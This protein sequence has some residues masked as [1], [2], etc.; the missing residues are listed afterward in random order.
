MTESGA[1]T[2][3]G[4]ISGSG[5]TLNKQGLGSLTLS[6]ASTYSG[7]TTIN[8]GSTIYAGSDSSDI[9]QSGPFG[10]GSVFV[11]NG[12]TLNLNGHSI[13]NSL[14][15]S[16]WGSNSGI[17]GALTN[18]GSSNSVVSGQVV[19]N[20]D[21]LFSGSNGYQING[22]ISGSYSLSIN[23]LTSIS[24][25]KPN[26][27]TGSTTIYGGKLVLG[28]NNAIPSLGLITI[29]Y[30]VLDINGKNPNITNITTNNL[31]GSGYN[32]SIVDSL[33]SGSITSS[34]ININ[35]NTIISAV[36][37]GNSSVNILSGGVTLTLSNINSYY[38]STNIS[39][40]QKLNITSTGSISQSST[41][42]VNGTLD[43]SNASSNVL[44]KSIS[45]TNS[46]G[47]IILG[48]NSL[49]LTAPNDIFPGVI[50]SNQ[51]ASAGLLVISG[52]ETFTNTNTYY[53]ATTINS[54]AAL[55]FGS[56]G[57]ALNSN[58][59]IVNGQLDITN[60]GGIFVKSLSGAGSIILGNVAITISNG[61]GNIFSGV[62]SGS[63]SGGGVIL[64]SGVITFTN[65]NTYT[66]ITTINSGTL[67]LSNSG[68][69]EQSSAVVLNGLGSISNFDISNSSGI[70]SIKSL[71]GTG[72]LNL[73]AQTI[74]ITAA[75]DNFSGVISGSG[76][77]IIGSL[78][79]N[80]ASSIGFLGSNT[81]TG[82]TTINYGSNLLL[83]SNGNISQSSN[84]IVKGTFDISNSSISINNINNLTDGSVNTGN[85][86]L[87]NN[88][89]N[90]NGSS[91]EYSGSIVGF[92]GL[93]LSSNSIETLSGVNTY[94]GNT[95]IELGSVLKIKNSGT[96]QNSNFV[97]NGT[98]DISNSTYNISI[99]NLSGNGG[100]IL[101]SN[102]LI[103]TNP[104]GLFGGI[105]SGSG[106]LSINV[107]SS[108]SQETLSGSN[109]YSGST[110]VSVN[111]SLYL[112]S[113]GSI[114]LS[115]LKVYGTFDISN[116]TTA[117][118]IKSIS[119]NGNIILS[120][121]SLILT[122]A[123]DIF[124]G[125]ISGAGGSFTLAGG[126]QTLTGINSYT[127]ITTINSG[128]LKL[129]NNSSNAI[130]NSASI[131]IGD[132]GVV[133]L[134]G[135]SLTVTAINSSYTN[136][137]IT[138]SG[139]SA[140]VL[141]IIGS[142]PGIYSGLIEDG[143]NILGLTLN[144]SGNFR[145]NQTPT[146]SG[147]TNISSNNTLSLSGNTNLNNSLLNIIGSFD[148][149][150]VNI[151]SSI[152]SLSGNGNVILGNNNLT[153]SN[154]NDI[155]AGV[156]S[157]Q[158]GIILAAGTL[159][160]TNTNTYSGFTKINAGTLVLANVSGSSLSQ[161]TDIIINNNGTLDLFGNSQT[162]NS[163]NSSSINSNIVNNG[164]TASTLVIS[165][166]GT[167][168][169]AGNIKDGT[170][171]IGLSLSGIG[172]LT[173]SQT[174]T[175]SGITTISSGK[176]LLG[177]NNAI[178]SSSDLIMNGSGILDLSGYS[179]TILSLSSDNL[180]NSIIL[181]SFINSNSII[182]VK[183]TKSTLYT[184]II[185]D[186]S[187]TGGTIS[188]VVAGSS[189]LK[190][191]GINTYTGN[192]NINEF[193]T[194]ILAN[195]NTN[196]IPA[197]S[198][199]YLNGNGT[200]DIF[201]YSQTF[202]SI[203][204]SSALTTITNN[205]I[206]PATLTINGI[207]PGYFNGAIKDGTSLVSFT[208]S[209]TGTYTLSG[210]N[211]FSGITTLNSGTLK[212][213]STNSFSQNSDVVMNSNSALDLASYSTVIGSLSSSS[214]Q[215]RVLNSVSGVSALSVSGTHSTNF[216]GLIIDNSGSGTGIVSLNIA[217]TGSLALTGVNQFSGGLTLSSGTLVVSQDTNL[218][219]VPITLTSGAL[220]F[221]GGT[222]ENIQNLTINSYRGIAFLNNGGNL[223]VDTNTTLIY[224][225]IITGTG[226]FTKSGLGNLLLTGSN[227]SGSGATLTSSY[228]GNVIIASGS[229]IIQNDSPLLSSINFSGNG[230]LIIQP[231]SVSFSSTISTSSINLSSTLNSLIIG[232]LGNLTQLTIDSNISTIGTQTYYGPVNIG[233]TI[234]NTVTLSTVSGNININGTI[235]NDIS[236]LKTLIINSAGT[237]AVNINSSIGSARPLG[238]VI[239]NAVNGVINI[240]GNISTIAA[241]NNGLYGEYYYNKGYF[242]DNL[243]WFNSNQ[244]TSNATYTTINNQSVPELTDYRFTAYFKP[245]V[246]GNYTFYLTSDDSS[247]MYIGTSGQIVSDLQTKLQ[248]GNGSINNFPNYFIINNSGGHGNTLVSGVA[249]SLI[250]GNLYPLVIYYANG[251]GA[252]G[253]LLNYS[254]PST[255]YN[256]T[257]NLSNEFY[258]L[259]SVSGQ[260]VL[261][262]PVVLT[263]NTN[264][265]SA[266]S[267]AAAIVGGPVSANISIDSINGSN[268]NLNIISGSFNALNSIG[269]NQALNNLNI[270]AS[271]INIK[272][273]QLSGLLSVTN[274]GVS[275]ISGA[276][277]G[278][279]L[280]KDGIGNLTLSGTNTYSQATTIN[281]GIFTISSIANLGNTNSIIINNNA[282]I[283]ISGGLS[284]PVSF[285]INGSGYLN[286]GAIYSSAG[287][288]TITSTINTISN[289][290]ISV[291][292]GSILDLSPS[293]T[294]AIIGL[295]TNINFNGSGTS[296]I[297]GYISIGS[298]SLVIQGPGTVKVKA[299][300]NNILNSSASFNITA[301]TFD[302]NSTSQIINSVSISGGSIINGSIVSSNNVVFSNDSNNPINI[303]ASITGS[304]TN[305]G[306]T[307]LGN[308]I[309]TLS[310]NNNFSGLIS[311]SNGTL[312]LNS[313][314]AIGSNVLST[315]SFDG[316]T[317]QYSNNNTTDYSNRFSQ[318]DGQKYIVNLANQ[319]ITWSSSLISNNSLLYINDSI[320]SG[321]LNLQN[322]NSSSFSAGVTLNKG[323]LYLGDN[324]NNSLGTAGQIIFSGGILKYS[325][326]NNFDYSSIFSNSV[327][328]N[329]Q[330]DTNGQVISW[331]SRLAPYSSSSL[332]KYGSGT[333]ILVNSTNSYSG[334]TV[335]NSGTIK[336][337]NNNVIPSTS[338][339]S[340]N[341]S[342][343]L[344]MAGF[345][346]TVAELSSNST[347][348]SITNSIAN[349][350]IFTTSNSNGG[351]TTTY[352]GSINNGASPGMTISL[353]K[354]GAYTLQLLGNSN[355][356]GSTSLQGG[357]INYGS[358]NA[359]G[360]T[361]TIYFYNN[362]LIRYTNSNTNDI[363]SRL[364][365]I[366]GQ[367]YYIDL[368]GYTVNWT[369]NLQPALNKS[370]SLKI[371]DSSSN[372]ILSLS[373]SNS[374]N[375]GIYLNSGTL[376][377]NSPNAIDTSGIV[378][379]NGGNLKFSANNTNDY[380]SVF[381]NSNNQNY[382][383]NLNNQSITFNYALSS[384]GGSLTIFDSS[385]LK[386]GMLLLN[387][388]N[389]Y[390]G[391]TTINSG[392]LKLLANS[393]LPNLKQININSGVLD[394]NGT[395]QSVGNLYL[396]TASIID[397]AITKGTLSA[398]SFTI[399]PY[400]SNASISANLSG[401]NAVLNLNGDHSQLLLS[402]NNSYSGGTT[403]NNWSSLTIANNNSLPLN[404]T[405]NV[406]TGY[407]DING[408]SP[409]LSTL[410]FGV[411]GISNSGNVNA[412]INSSNYIINLRGNN[413]T[414]SANLN[415]GSLALS[416]GGTL[417]L[418]GSNNYSGGTSV[419][420]AT[421]LIS[422]DSNL[423]QVIN[424]NQLIFNEGWLS[425]SANVTINSTRNIVNNGGRTLLNIPN[426]L[427]LTYA[428]IIS[429]NGGLYKEGYG[430]FN[431]SGTASF[432]NTTE[433]NN[434]SIYLSGT[435][436][437]FSSSKLIL[438]NSSVFDISLSN[439]G[440][441][442]NRLY[443]DYNTRIN[444][445]NN[446]FT[447]S[448]AD[449]DAFN[450]IMSSSGINGSF[451]LT[452]GNQIFRGTNNYLGSTTIGSSASLI[453]YSSGSIN[454]GVSGTYSNSIINNG[455]LEYSSSS[456]LILSGLISGSGRLV[457]YGSA[458][459]T[460][461]NNNTF[462]GGI[463]LNSGTLSISSDGNL[464]LQPQA[465]SQSNISIS[466]ATLLITANTDW[467]SNRGLYLSGTDYINVRQ[468]NYLNINSIISGSF[469]TLILNDQG[470][471]RFNGNN[472]YTG[473][474]NVNSG[475]LTINNDNPKL[476]G[477]IFNGNGQLTIQ[478]SSANFS[479]L[480]NFN[481]LKL[482]QTLSSLTIG[483]T[484]NT[485]P[486]NLISDISTTG[487]QYYYGP[488]L[489]SKS[490]SLNSSSGN[491]SFSSTVDS[492]TSTTP[493][494]LTIN[495][496]SSLYKVS[497][498]DVIGGINP[499]GM[500][501]IN[502]SGGIALNSN[503]F[504]TPTNFNN[505][506]KTGLVETLFNSFYFNNNL[507]LFA[508]NYYSSSIF[509][510][511][512][513]NFTINAPNPSGN[514]GITSYTYNNQNFSIIFSGYYIP[515]AS[516]VASF[517][518]TSTDSSYVYLGTSGQ[519]VS[520]LQQNI[521]QS[522]LTNI[523]RIVNNQYPSGTV[524]GNT[525]SLIAGQ[526]Y[527]ILIY[528]GNGSDSGRFS[529][530]NTGTGQYVTTPPVQSGGVVL[531]GPV[532]LTSNSTISTFNGPVSFTNILNGLTSGINLN[533]N[534]G[535]GN[536]N[537]NGSV[538]ALQA[539]GNISLAG[540]SINSSL[541]NLS[542]A[543]VITNS[544]QS[545]IGGSISGTSL[546]KNGIGNLI[547]S[548]TNTYS[549]STNLNAGT[550]TLGSNT[551]FSSGSI[552]NINY[553]VLDMYSYNSTISNL[554]I[555]AG[556]IINSNIT[557]TSTLTATQF[558]FNN[559]VSN[560]VLV[561]VVLAGSNST[562]GTNLSG[563]GN[564]TFTGINTYTG[565]T[566]VSQV[567]TLI[568]SGSGSIAT[569][570][571]LNLNGVF[572]ISNVTST[573]T[574]NGLSGNSY[575]SVLT[576]SKS[577]ILSNPLFVTDV[578]YGVI[579]GSG[580][581]VLNSGVETLSG[582][583]TYSG[584]TTIS[585]GS[586]IIG[587]AGTLGV[588]SNYSGSISISLGAFFNFSSSSNQILSG[589]ISG[590]GGIVK[591][592][593]SNSNLTISNSNT[594]SGST[595]IKFGTIIVSNSNSLGNSSNVTISNNSSL[596]INGNNLTLNQPIYLNG[597]GLNNAGALI[598]NGNN[599]TIAGTIIL[600]S[601]SSV[602]TISGNL[603]LNGLSG[604][605]IS[606]SS[607]N[608]ILNTLSNIYI[609]NSIN[610]GSGSVSIVG[611][612]TV[613]FSGNNSYTGN[614]N[615]SN[616]STLK[617]NLSGSISS[618]STIIDE[619]IF[620]ITNVSSTATIKSLSSVSYTSSVLLGIKSLIISSGND[621]FNGIISGSGD[622]SLTSGRQ[623][624][625][626]ANLY[627]GN[628]FIN[629]GTL[630]ISGSGSLGLS[631]IYSSTIS[632][633]NNSY[634]YYS[635]SANQTISGLI[636]GL[637]N[638]TKD[639]SNSSVLT[640][641]HTNSYSG[642]TTISSG[643]INI[644]NNMSLGSTSLVTVFGGAELDLNGTTLN[645]SQPIKLNGAVGLGA[646]GALVNVTGNN[647]IS[648]IILLGGNGKILSS[649]G[650]ITIVGNG[651]KSI[652]STNNNLILS[653][654]TGN[655]I[656]SNDISIGTGS[657]TIDGS[658]NVTLTYANSFSGQTNINTGSNLSI[659]GNGSISN[660]SNI[661]INGLLDISGSYANA[662][663]S[664]I[665]GTNSN[666]VLS[667]GSK[668]LSITNASNSEFLGVISGFGSVTLGSGHQIL[669][670]N[671]TYSGN[672]IINSGTLT[673]GGSGS[674][675]NGNYSGQIIINQSSL[676]QYSSS[677]NQ[678]LSGIISGS[679]SISKDINNISILTLS[680]S[681]TYSGYSTINNG[682]ILVNNNN[683]LGVS[684][685][686]GTII[687]YNGI[688]ALSGGLTIYQPIT[689]G[690]S[691]IYSAKLINVSGNNN[692][693]KFVS[694]N[695]NATLQSLTG[696]LSIVGSSGISI[697]S[698]S[699]VLTLDANS[700]SIYIN[701]RI[702]IGSGSLNVTGTGLVTLSSLNSYS[703]VTNVYSG[704]SLILN[705]SSASISGS[706]DVI[707]N[708]LLDLVNV[709]NT[710]LQS[711]GGSYSGLIN[712]GSSTLSITAANDNF[713]G[714]ISGSG[715]SVILTG[716]N[717]AFSGNN[718]FTGGMFINGG[719]LELRS[720]GSLGAISNAVT[721]NNATVD[722]QT[723]VTVGSL[724]M[725][726]AAP[727]IINS[728]GASS[729]TVNGASTLANSI[730]TS[731]SQ[732]YSGV[733]TLGANTTLSGASL[734]FGTTL[735]GAR[736]LSTRT[737]GGT[738]FSGA[739]GGNTALSGLTLTTAT[740]SAGAINLSNAAAL[741]V[742]E[743][744]AGTITGVI[745]EIGRA[746]V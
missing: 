17:T 162:I 539:F 655:I 78:V 273:I 57:S 567:S 325:S 499:L 282:T 552:L 507:N 538:G 184:G 276:Y 202:S 201:G 636:S 161:T 362:S 189:T 327:V 649:S 450:G 695:G 412:S 607:S 308:G 83:I 518:T 77:I 255:S 376:L 73:G 82:T 99:T 109:T 473:I 732:T 253:I 700:G 354:S 43:L 491:I 429:G 236:N 620:D 610:I 455:T 291:A 534:S 242:S 502:S 241:L 323:T 86:K 599:N 619:G 395:T 401:N 335:I 149:T 574:I 621:T 694:L 589:N 271:A 592:L 283:S 745:S 292:A 74:S 52:R 279:G 214:L 439:T 349:S 641:S 719:Q 432:T 413:S 318:A 237:G 522:N 97:V 741:S 113:S 523:N 230:N 117:V 378:N 259:S 225:G 674:L 652:S 293:S 704:S 510:S 229:L 247:L 456:N 125:N 606:S 558:N 330:V 93:K 453:F 364:S 415:G 726:G 206:S 18:T 351:I 139:N 106:G 173:L 32:V 711:I 698:S 447:I 65:L 692:I 16:G 737:T 744:G 556:S 496:A 492:S 42:V 512:A 94:L 326:S 70:V 231:N 272:D 465:Y 528:Y 342:S 350:S 532:S 418:S 470:S 339:L 365:N 677:V 130:P 67:L 28:D 369:A 486:I 71:R 427:T 182:T 15:L 310:G 287:S 375:S 597:F 667:L 76:N 59:Y 131:I 12:A 150:N 290:L 193:A 601:D 616:L 474:I 343:T 394:I 490:I 407:L 670:G 112:T 540:S 185:K 313:A 128:T 501:V 683:S 479:N 524:S 157:G 651:L 614:T 314:G 31:Y 341:N 637:G 476:S 123:N 305:F 190:L 216:A 600:Q 464:G 5:V 403:I 482:P 380:S 389:S 381:S 120:S 477:I 547:L 624:L 483:K 660:S 213:G 706:S 722:L 612:G 662:I 35:N 377:L 127:G 134:A 529:F 100:F 573:S 526:V 275:N 191:T 519:S 165:G 374:F 320:G 302:E 727:V 248:S 69:I 346:L 34:S 494:G 1:G 594:Y 615:I 530:S 224:Q 137:K 542:G 244:P 220:S 328:Q 129:A 686:S 554:N 264:I 393:S 605:S 38:G 192:T 701:N 281:N 3:T 133:D 436:S 284:I 148:I 516:G 332:T 315:I 708:G 391:V 699:G 714:V 731:G 493:F 520:L 643:I 51:V 268:N 430:I 435:G 280:F 7:G 37:S 58:N 383:I 270:N 108:S 306:L 707:V 495:L 680:N 645:I 654:N 426:G 438:R 40:G 690:S 169:F 565:I 568:L 14:Y 198:T 480:A 379:F 135:Y 356:S 136:S 79:G 132:G 142:T 301:G 424:T 215:T 111:A 471:V 679:G 665:G 581:L 232:K 181:N 742:T 168:V 92:G 410:Y 434:G 487:S 467:N 194:L 489:L 734:T 196:T 146:Y 266:P 75:S 116:S 678:L 10:T 300:L 263:G 103:L 657:L 587:G 406:Y 640:L 267:I 204:G 274:T 361:G 572:D 160:L 390:S 454:D 175:Y 500:L 595:S 285:A 385:I 372:G 352:Y 689:I 588:S 417:T 319:N 72:N 39:N 425:I 101:G 246:S 289:S 156:I 647:T 511:S 445:G 238:Q 107:L 33:N 443:G 303:T 84:V 696:V 219:T 115:G 566:S 736:T 485:T 738:T 440:A 170:G 262:G 254:G 46:A 402:G 211:T 672:T 635:S 409:T 4:V 459:L 513:T 627:S 234:V 688:L 277:S 207:T 256:T 258:S 317:L 551:V 578:F 251:G 603:S 545:S 602:S 543:L 235:D 29:Y 468:N 559:S 420:G 712:L 650:S 45:G 541:I 295:N 200:L 155:F 147:I 508:T 56:G 484:G 546:T 144:G 681:N 143:S 298:G 449:G 623:G 446:P 178:S 174:N 98:V 709:G 629:G 570:K 408:F 20:A 725:S 691:S 416:N 585:A 723:G 60:S 85:I 309:L 53:G 311:I 239:I 370:I 466:N 371:I 478:P 488:L 222:L 245:T 55:I 9:A 228:S 21:T 118:S 209:S 525:S 613:T 428:G 622:L 618:S 515:D 188:L 122:A 517:S 400:Y 419:S 331:S 63:G 630:S 703:G 506:S 353:V 673:I 217:T 582:A 243:T 312:I 560:P 166:N 26:I 2:I 105:I 593:S 527:P 555:Y 19:L 564:V 433:I 625:S 360:S 176:L 431:Y 628:T 226:G 152:K 64:N 278:V 521:Q 102:N 294:N 617:L 221:K 210:S 11:Q 668:S 598:N 261:N 457:T 13:S 452:A 693:S 183:G 177:V 348:A 514:S 583:N 337:G 286:M 340:I 713:M 451:S 498:A 633:A 591:D 388:T 195:N 571:D 644:T 460:L 531:N 288:N 397:S 746:H 126:I 405:V 179:Q 743:S 659:S 145:L 384:N 733:V 304:G 437:I 575:G 533:I 227:T 218:G 66:G 569:S 338:A 296:N 90:L 720:G 121:K 608:L 363:S 27:Y 557:G 153:I 561:S 87:G 422:S 584:S 548:G 30:G 138:N 730:T 563:A 509:N 164:I 444:F 724:V 472:T 205:G 347:S 697:T 197:I 23:V 396:N 167:S 199:I 240:G 740:L 710:S 265:T 404:S 22:V 367:L 717:Q 718:S 735:D 24:F 299:G 187:G 269:K 322:T 366:D 646:S 36:I 387:S 321:T 648:N 141:T 249:S 671:N 140:V 611:L 223:L 577:L 50:S 441:S 590:A 80:N 41:L 91:G 316:G 297:N 186:N 663:V 604:L 95:N 336:L 586:L 475:S 675:Q 110:T 461:T 653:A 414:I 358:S 549:S 212:L 716:G 661:I 562:V 203:Y 368:N 307:K 728:T 171:T 634:F 729:L 656:I 423:G 172:N 505:P 344:D 399:N 329:Y 114:S 163:I 154:A 44:I 49:T 252:G 626:G 208:L 715:G 580:S 685:G 81:Y 702:S 481:D 257:S 359:L 579:S 639:T 151:S 334:S 382:N 47:S 345:N 553:G 250:A 463:S 739:V 373:G 104:S 260:V 159:K 324:S 411:G 544:S 398:V 62:I 684:N 392:T 664:G 462:S 158:G 504:T 448:N 421:L 676:F 550:L 666:G 721:I 682:T 333:L 669:S 576:G 61:N 48:D 386:Q 469:N 631:N 357:V 535:S 642:T 124:S 68:S 180:N 6:G 355:Y 632:I 638:I 442:I 658:S 25:N 8:N 96:V 497:F 503:I 458:L 119:G 537:L 687:N 233:S 89:L 54:N 609:P 88:Y 705:T 536:I 596:Y